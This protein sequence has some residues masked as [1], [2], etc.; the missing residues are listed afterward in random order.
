MI[1]FGVRGDGVDVGV[2]WCV[3]RQNDDADLSSAGGRRAT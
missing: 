1:R 3:S 2:R